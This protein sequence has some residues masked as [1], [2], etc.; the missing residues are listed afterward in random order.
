MFN[1]FI[2]NGSSISLIL[3][4]FSSGV[5]YDVIMVV[6]SHRAVLPPK[7]YRNP[8]STIL[9]FIGVGCFLWPAIYVGIYEGIIVGILFWVIQQLIGQI[10]ISPMTGIQQD[11]GRGV[12]FYILALI[13]FPIGYYLSIKT[14]L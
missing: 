7:I 3:M 4:V 13:S 8:I 10:V 11:A 1:N 5:L 9:I 2:T 12:F 14:L 6:H